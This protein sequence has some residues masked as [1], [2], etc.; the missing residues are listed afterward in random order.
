M[1]L[2]E[3]KNFFELGVAFAQF[4]A[5]SEEKNY[6]N[7]RKIALALEL[8]FPNHDDL[9]GKLWWDF[10]PPA[11]WFK[12]SDG[13][14]F[15]NCYEIGI[16]A[17]LRFLLAL[18][19]STRTEQISEAEQKL[20][21][22]FVEENIAPE[23][24][25]DYLAGLDTDD[26]S[27]INASLRTFVQNFPKAFR[28]EQIFDNLGSAPLVFD[29][30][31]SETLRLTIDEA[32]ICYKNKCYLATIAL[33]GKIIETLLANAFQALMEKTPPEKMGFG[34]IRK[35]LR[36]KGM[37][38][39]DSVDELLELIYTHRSIVVH[40]SSTGSHIRYVSYPTKE[41]A[42][43]LAGLTQVVINVIYDY[44]NSQ[45]DLSENSPNGA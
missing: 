42:M 41:Q 16:L 24:L 39:D 7:T 21:D 4:S 29:D 33:C 1:N 20:K 15:R 45:A 23:V 10:V 2:N 12:G 35:A 36:G 32:S 22:L 17:Y 26:P 25:G 37:P 31:V 13:E 11:K 9:K 5:N 18:P 14:S 43:P 6:E 8:E 3:L 40:H 28:K 30:K 44:F 19:P 27:K 38:L 34:E